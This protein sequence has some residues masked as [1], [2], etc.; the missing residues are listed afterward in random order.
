MLALRVEFPLPHEHVRQSRKDSSALSTE[1]ES[2]STVVRSLKGW[3][4]VSPGCLSSVVY[5][6]RKIEIPE[7]AVIASVS[8]IERSWA[9]SIRR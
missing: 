4:K 5:T 8:E 3:S 9:S 7:N 1:S 6:C 2:N